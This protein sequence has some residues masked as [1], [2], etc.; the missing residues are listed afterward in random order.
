MTDPKTGGP[1]ISKALKEYAEPAMSGPIRLTVGD[2]FVELEP[3]ELAPALKLTGNADGTVTPSLDA[4][5]LEP[6]FKERFKDLETLPKDATF[7][8]S[9]GKPHV[10]QAVDGMVVARDKVV[11]AILATLPKPV[12]QRKVA[13][14][15][16]KTPAKLT[17]AQAQALGVKELMGGFE[18][19]L[20]PRGVPQRQHRHGGAADQR[21]P[22][23][24]ERDVQPEQDRRRA[25]PG[26]RLH[27]GQHHQ[28]RQV[29]EGSRRR[30]LAV[31]DHHLSTLPSSPA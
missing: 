4:A 13:V 27:R 12:G 2:K 7:E 11:T 15:L 28:R 3:K 26:E 21:H 23:E 10:V 30:R 31:G 22:A 29:R 8:I 24:A 18:T 19:D 9:G 17:T 25:H 1:A 5:K 16:A 6:L 14:D 20:P